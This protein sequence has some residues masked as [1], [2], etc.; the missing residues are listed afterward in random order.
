MRCSF[1]LSC[2]VAGLAVSPTA[3]R[4]DDRTNPKLDQLD[5]CTKASTVTSDILD[6]LADANRRD[7]AVLNSTYRQV[8]LRLDA[9]QR[10]KLR[11]SERR[12]LDKRKRDCNREALA[13]STGSWWPVMYGSCIDDSTNTRIAWLLTH[14]R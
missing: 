11:A 8:M 3:A 4:P 9:T 13:Y 10:L 5:I 2:A 12:W 6:C 14:Y 7:D 1:I